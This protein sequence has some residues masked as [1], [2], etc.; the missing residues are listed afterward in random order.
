MVRKIFHIYEIFD[1]IIN[2][3]CSK[4]TKCI[5]TTIGK[6]CKYRKYKN[7]LWHLFYARSFYVSTK[8]NYLIFY[9]NTNGF[10][11]DRDVRY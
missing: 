8:Y 10:I 6:T 5:F 7:L 1:H 9:S 2:V 4:I 11:F 3:L